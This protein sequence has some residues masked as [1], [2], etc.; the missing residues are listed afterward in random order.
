VKSLLKSCAITAILLIAMAPVASALLMDPNTQP[1]F[2]NPL[3]QPPVLTDDDLEISIEQ[4]QMNMGLVDPVT[5]VPLLTTLYGYNGIFPG[6]SIVAVKGVPTSIVFHN[7]LPV[8]PH[9]LQ[10]AFDTTIGHPDLPAGRIP[11][12]VHLHGGE[13]EPQSDGGPFTW[14]TQGFGETGPHWTSPTYHYVN[15]QPAATL[16]YHDHAFGYTRFNPYCGLAGFYLVVDPPTEGPLNLPAAPYDLGICVQDKSFNTDGSLFYDT[17]GVDPSVH[18]KWVPEF[19]GDHVVVNGIIWP[20]QDVEPRKYRFRFLNG[21]QA[22]F[23]SLFL[24]DQATGAGGPAFYQIATEGGYLPAP[25]MLNDPLNVM[26]PKLIIAPGERADVV[27]DFSANAPGTNFILRNNAKA[28]FPAGVPANPQTTG[29]IMQFRVV[30]LTDTDN[31]SLPPVLNT[32]PTLTPTVTRQL[33]LNEVVGPLGPI[34]M[35]LDGRAL[36]DPAS[37]TPTLGTTEQWDI[38]NMTADAHPIHTHLVQFQVL[39]RQR[40]DVKKYTAAYTAANP[41]LPTENPVPVDVTPFLKGPII[42]PDLNEIGWQDTDRMPPGQVTR[43]L[44]RAAPTDGTPNYAFDATAAPGYV[45]HCHILEHEENDMM[46]P[47]IILPPPPPKLVGPTSGALPV[48][49]ALNQNYP[50]PFNASTNISFDLPEAGQVKIDIF[51]I[52]GEKV[53]TLLEDNLQAGSH[54]VTWNAGGLASGIYLAKLSTHHGTLTRHMVIL[55]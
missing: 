24:V 11:V 26:A 16:W 40:F 10:S 36:F 29:R 8:G 38:I 13:D 18:P 50:N 7:N 41:V 17:I 5:G 31:S 53:A 49:A 21:S 44:F 39:N 48:A 4:F 28:P 55:K 51:N 34:A 52:L 3:P 12:T 9:I 15:T 25:V 19:F 37:E 23:Y 30:P 46:R 27:I 54:T 6:P 20:Y 45:W 43:I 14:F 32:I 33:T 2:V 1:K 35:F 42:P 47:L 22:R